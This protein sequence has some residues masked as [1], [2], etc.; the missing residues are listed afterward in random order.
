MFLILSYTNYKSAIPNNPEIF[1]F[2]FYLGTVV[3]PL[4][5]T[6]FVSKCLSSD[7]QI[8]FDI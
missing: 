6:N 5:L 8:V 4:M 2:R 7:F 1:K 3:W